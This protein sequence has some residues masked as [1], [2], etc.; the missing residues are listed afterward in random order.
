MAEENTGKITLP[1]QAGVILIMI[2]NIVLAVMLWQAREARMLQLPPDVPF[3]TGYFTAIASGTGILILISS[4][5]ALSGQL[6]KLF[7]QALTWIWIV[8]SLVALVLASVFVPALSEYLAP[9]LFWLLIADAGLLLIV[10]AGTLVKMN[11]AELGRNVLAILAGIGFTFLMLEIL[12]RVYFGFMGTEAQRV[13]YLYSIDRI[14]E[15]SNRYEGLPYVNY[16]LSPTHREHNSRGYRGAEFSIPKDE[17]IFRI[18]ALGG[19]TTYG[20]SILPEEAYPA[21]LQQILH[22]EYGYTHVEVVNAG[23][24]AYSSFDSL[25]NLT[26]HVLDDDPDMVIVYHGI[27]DVRARLVEPSQYSGGNLQRGYWNIEALRRSLNPSVIIRFSSI[28][29]GF[30]PNPNLFETVLSTGNQIPRCGLFEVTCESLGNRPAADIIAENPPLYFERN[31]RNITAIATANG[32]DVVFSTWEYYAGELDWPNPMTLEHMQDAVDE[33][34][35]LLIDF[36]AEMD[37]PVIDFAAADVIDSPEYWIDGM[38]MLPGGTRAQA[39]FY[40]A[41]LIENDLLPPPPAN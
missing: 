12:L 29:L 33:Q 38:H 22:D 18:F 17:G 11:G 4:T 23:V 34:N 14:L 15:V 8:V 20:D 24:N 2:A 3:F 25:A 30:A 40:A 35:A 9:F 32:A 41:Y 21:V 36:A 1:I 13:A 28:Q 5:L 16:G 39:E 7:N 6:A 26:Y 37:V 19:S 10:Y 31:Y 27:N